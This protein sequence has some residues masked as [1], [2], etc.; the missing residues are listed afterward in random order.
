MIC[1]PDDLGPEVNVTP[2]QTEGLGNAEASRRCQQC[3]GAAISANLIWAH[4]EIAIL[5][6]CAEKTQPVHFFPCTG[7]RR[8]HTNQPDSDGALDAPAFSPPTYVEPQ[9]SRWPCLHVMLVSG[10]GGFEIVQKALAAGIPILA[11]VSAPSRVAVKLA[12]DLGLT[13]IEFLGG[14]G[15]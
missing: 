12:R 9:D 2:L 4:P 8:K 7:F 1:A 5:D 14:D 6:D 11:S 15:L 10:S 13:R 3:Q